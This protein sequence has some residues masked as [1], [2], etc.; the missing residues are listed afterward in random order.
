[1][2]YLKYLDKGRTIFEGERCKSWGGAAGETPTG[3]QV[4]RPRLTGMTLRDLL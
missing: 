3:L 1:M 2:S 4:D